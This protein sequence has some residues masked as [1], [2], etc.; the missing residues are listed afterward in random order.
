MIGTRH[1]CGFVE[2][3]DHDDIINV[4][5]KYRKL[6]VFCCSARAGACLARAY[7]ASE[8]AGVRQARRACSSAP[9]FYR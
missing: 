6:S 2:G 8:R 5:T 1:L 7:A 9:G 4:T 3:I